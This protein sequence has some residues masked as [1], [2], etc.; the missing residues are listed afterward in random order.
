[1]PAAPEKAK[2]KATGKSQRAK[3]KKITG[4]PDETLFQILNLLAHLLYEYFI[5]IALRDTRHRPTLNRACSL[6]G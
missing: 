2:G 3:G 6:R 1:M 4:L 5:S